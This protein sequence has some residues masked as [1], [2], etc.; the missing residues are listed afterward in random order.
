MTQIGPN[1]TV[2]V[3]SDL[4][5]ATAA[6]LVGLAGLAIADIALPQVGVQTR[7]GQIWKMDTESLLQLPDTLRARGSGYNRIRTKMTPSTFTCEQNAIEEAVLVED[8]AEFGEFFAGEMSASIRCRDIVLRARENR[9]ASALFN[10]TT[11]PASGTTGLTVGTAWTNAA[12]TPAANVN[13]VA[14]FIYNK[15]GITKDQLSLIVPYESLQLLSFVTDYI[16]KMKLDVSEMGAD[17]SAQ[18]AAKYFGVKEVLV[19][20][21]TYNNAKDNQTAVPTAIWNKNYAFLF[22][23]MEA[24]RAIGAGEIDAGVVGLGCSPRWDRMDSGSYGVYSYGENNTDSGIVRVSQY[25][26][27]IICNTECGALIKGI[28]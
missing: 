21:M 4:A 7:T 8:T 13:T 23:R 20:R 2:V 11:F 6:T 17:V 22:H 9:V 19:G 18:Q 25:V 1:L 15:T 12:A 27:E 10:E 26:D 16:T 14:T 3:R 24:A 5:I 28:N